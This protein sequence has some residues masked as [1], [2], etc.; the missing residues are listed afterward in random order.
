MA[1]VEVE[2][3]EE[4]EVEVMKAVIVSLTYYSLSLENISHPQTHQ[5]QYH[6]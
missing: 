4:E 2:E 1:K 3:E 6:R 5:Q